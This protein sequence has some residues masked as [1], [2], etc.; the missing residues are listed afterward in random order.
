MNLMSSQTLLAVLKAAAILHLLALMAQPIFIGQYFSGLP[1]ALGLHGM[2]AEALVWL[3]LVQ[4][5]L[6]LLCWFRAGLR[7]PL[8]LALAAIWLG[9]GLQIHLGYVRQVAVHVPLG[10]ALLAVS[11]AVT[12][13]LWRGA[14]H[15]SETGELSRP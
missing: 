11:L 15:S 2:G 9:D 3:G 8:M 7:T 14:A 4:A 10:A 13:W 1:D 12:L 5:L 6:G